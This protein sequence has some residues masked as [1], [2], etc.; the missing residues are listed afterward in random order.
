WS[1][2]RAPGRR[3]RGGASTRRGWAGRESA[4]RNPRRLPTLRGQDA[5]PPRPEGGS[6]MTDEP[7]CAGEACGDQAAQA[8]GSVR[9]R[10]VCDVPRDDALAI[11]RVANLVASPVSRGV[12]GPI[13]AL[14]HSDAAAGANRTR[15]LI[16]EPRRLWLT[17]VHVVNI[18]TYRPFSAGASGPHVVT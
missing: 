9:N 18:V 3:R 6:S 7:A 1:P 17:P 4:R 8:G 13:S 2:T 11:H 14:A 15:R 10:L 16:G 5:P 12:R